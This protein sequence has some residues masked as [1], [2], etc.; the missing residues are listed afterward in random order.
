MD[1][2]SH[3]KVLGV[4]DLVG[5]GGVEYGLGVDTGLVMESGVAGY[6]VVERYV[7]LDG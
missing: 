7:D 4:D 5:A 1:E 3:A 2:A 6:V